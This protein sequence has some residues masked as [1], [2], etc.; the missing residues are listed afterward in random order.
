[1]PWFSDRA[2]P[3][4]ARA[5]AAGMLPSAFWT[6]S[7]PGLGISV[8]VGTAL[9]GGP[10]HRCKRAGLPHWAPGLDTDVESHVRPRMH[11]VDWR[12]PSVRKAGHPIPVQAGAL[13]AAPKRLIPVPCRLEPEGVDRRDIAGHSV[14]VEVSSNHRCRAS[15]PARGRAG[16]GVS[17]TR[18]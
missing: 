16:A 15:G 12:E 14:V 4:T 8:A 7:A 13:A 11:D 17:G 3:L 5:D 2:G 6:T 10:P 18:F 9:K 1:M